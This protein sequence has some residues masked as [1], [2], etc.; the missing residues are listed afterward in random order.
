MMAQSLPRAA[1]RGAQSFF[2]LSRCH[3]STRTRRS[4]DG[5]AR[6]A[7]SSAYAARRQQHFVRS[8]LFV[9][10]A[11]GL[12]TSY[13][14]FSH[15]TFFR[16]VHAEAPPS[17][18]V[19]PGAEAAFEK[20]RRKAAT[21]EENRDILSS[22][23]LQVKRSWESPGVYAWGSNMGKVVAPESDEGTV[24]APRRIAAFDG[25]LLRDLKLARDF[26]AAVDEEGDLL[27]WGAAFM[28]DGGAKPEPEATLKGKKLTSISI[29]ADRI[30]GLSGDGRVYSVAVNRAEQESGP[31]PVED[32]WL[33]FWSSRSAVSYRQLRPRNLGW[34]EKVTAIAG[35]QE[36]VLLLTS[37]G[38]VF[39]AAASGESYPK[40]GQLGVPGLTWLSRPEGPFDAC[41]E[42]T[43][44]K[45]FDIVRVAAGDYHSL[46]LDREGRVF[47][48]GDNQFGQLGIETDAESSMVDAP[49]LI[50]LHRLY[51]PSSNLRARVTGLAAG[52][53]NTFFTVDTTRVEGA[54]DSKSNLR[55]QRE[56]GRVTADV[57]ACGQGI[58]GALGN[59]RWTHVQSTP[60]KVGALSGLFEYDDKTQ[61]PSPIRL[62]RFSVGATHVAAVMDNLTSTAVDS[63]GGKGGGGENDINWGADV[64][65]W[66]GNEFFQ[67]G[68]GKRNNVSNPTYIQA[69]DEA[70]ERKIRGKEREQHRFQITPRKKVKVGGRLVSMEQRV[71]CGD[72][73]TAV[74]SAV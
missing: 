37:H 33:P 60:I 13:Q 36:H 72:G 29:S 1:P 69:L 6:T 57:W 15:G 74:Y 30:I 53:N 41:H 16:D 63:V 8:I 27:Q 58:T 4:A 70:A 19:T 44:L 68:T 34:G 14:W 54:G 71:V 38:R 55:A 50:P 18:A 62:A 64:L 43:T 65:F 59:G 24:K 49:S 66:G 2:H 51:P 25:V 47:S 73:V 45:G 52:G 67:L 7:T 11:G 32:S 3:L 20:P 23:H 12:A 48:F 39:S 21:K 42:L 22:Q 31:K 17:P 5:F 46:V 26:G 56:I 28:S 61:R 10:I 40:R 9:A 35:G